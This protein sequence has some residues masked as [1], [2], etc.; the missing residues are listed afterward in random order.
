MLINEV[1]KITGL[2]KKAIEYY[3]LQGLISPKILENG[4][5]DFDE[6]GIDRL[7]KIYVLRKLGIGTDDIKTV[8]DDASGKSLQTIAI[9]K[10]LSLQREQAK[11]AILYKL[12]NS[13]SFSE[14]SAELEAIDR[15][16]TIAEK[17]LEAFPGYYGRYLCLHFA[18]FL[19]EPISTEKQQAAY[20]RI[21]SFLDDL[22]P[23]DFPDDLKEY[24]IEATEYMGTEE[25]NAM[26]DNLKRVTEDPDG[27]LSEN[28]EILDQYLKYR[29]SCE[30]RNSPAYRIMELTKG[31]FS[32]SGYNDIFI[33]A[34][35]E[36]S[37]SYA[38]YHK[39]L[40]E[41]NEKLLA[42]YPDMG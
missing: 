34:M 13:L 11:K 24:L 28:K 20:E 26:N 2:T 5:R 27:Y 6:N 22:P 8:L 1:N 15:G 17:L 37:S 39:R 12:G 25:I 36:L 14:A 38:E 29:Q 7:K 23:L 10:E 21:I 33:P 4:Y 41:A 30:Y 19:N 18:P 42:Q 16:I 9:R 32:S 31:F 3:T 40:E 35:K